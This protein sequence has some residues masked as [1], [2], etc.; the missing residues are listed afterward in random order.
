MKKFVLFTV[1]VIM[2]FTLFGCSAGA[3]KNVD[4]KLPEQKTQSE[5]VEN[6]PAENSSKQANKTDETKTTENET[7]QP[8]K[9]I[10]KKIEVLV[11][12]EREMREATLAESKY[13]G[14]RIY[15]LKGYSLESEEPGK[16]IIISN[17]DGDFF[18]RIEKLDGKINIDEYKNQQKAGFAQ[19]G[20]VTE[21]DPATVFHE[22]FRDAKFWLLIE[23]GYSDNSSKKNSINYLVKEFNG[24]LF[25]ITFHMPLKEAA[26]GIT[27][28]LW[29][30][31]ST[32][33]AQ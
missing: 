3:N 14:Y 12:G 2:G 30:I 6:Q 32:M 5:A 11:E 28:S 25:A 21:R 8:K 26:E 33:E 24:Q 15:V 16:D 17:Y 4:K 9:E 27:P 19:T 23:S 22:K 31:V 29:A 20:K 10:T 1:I 13:L 18:A 7:V